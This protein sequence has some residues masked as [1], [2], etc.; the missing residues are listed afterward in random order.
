M[1]ALAVLDQQQADAD[2]QDIEED[3]EAARIGAH[4]Q[5]EAAEEE[6]HRDNDDD[7]AQGMAAPAD[8]HVEGFAAAHPAPAVIVEI[9]A[10]G[11]GEEQQGVEE[12][13]VLEEARHVPHER[14]VEREQGESQQAA[15]RRRRGVGHAEQAGELVGQL[16]EAFIAVAPADDLDDHGE[17][18]HA[19]HKSP[20]EEVHLR[21][22]PD[23]FA[24]I[25][26]HELA[27]FVD[28]LSQ[29]GECCQ[30]GAHAQGKRQ[31]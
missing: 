3:H 24:R 8:E 18:R 31:A 22:K 23:K 1:D 12:H 21:Q 26:S 16:I 11:L 13:D 20:E 10:E 27:V 28:V 19:Q 25:Q 2:G 5:T 15:Q 29:G 4:F 6:H 7:G 9:E 17:Q 14:R 30:G